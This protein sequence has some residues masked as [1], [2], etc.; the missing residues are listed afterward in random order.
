M[1]RLR[2]PILPALFC[3][4]AAWTL[5]A[6][7]APTANAASA[8]L[9]HCLDPARELVLRSL[10][11]NCEGEVLTAEEAERWRERVRA[12]RVER[13][14]RAGTEVEEPRERPTQTGTGFR[15]DAQGHLVTGRHVVEGC[16]RLRL[17]QDGRL[18]GEARV[19]ALHPLL[20]VALLDSDAGGPFARFADGWPG[21][22]AGGA[23]ALDRFGIVGYPS[24]GVATVEAR[25]AEAVARSDLVVGGK[26][27]VHFLGV[28][29]PGHSGSPLLD[30]RGRVAG[31]VI[32]KRDQVS[33]FAQSGELPPESGLALD[34]EQLRRF[35]AGQG[36]TVETAPA[37]ARRL[38]PEALLAQARRYVLRIDCWR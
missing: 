3:L 4:A 14:R 25:L 34:G 11:W 36:V 18:L 30:A 32:A 10:P 37:T 24:E 27:F 22:A 15:V 17:R 21:A 20:D 2:F 35:L 26:T 8:E 13:I 23:E 31:L 29:R 6:G 38:D 1:P 9:V 28:V 12:R 19:R 33:A 7:G 5:S 16:R